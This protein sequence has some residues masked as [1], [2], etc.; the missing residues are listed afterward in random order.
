MIFFLLLFYVH[1]S[2]GFLCVLHSRFHL[3]TS[4]P[5]KVFTA[6]CVESN[7]VKLLVQRVVCIAYYYD[8]L[9]CKQQKYNF[10]PSEVQLSQRRQMGCCSGNVCTF[11][12]IRPCKAA[13]KHLCV[14]V[15]AM[16][17]FIAHDFNFCVIP[18]F[19]S[20]IISL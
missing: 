2:G 12:Y 14:L 20:Y 13:A 4:R 19:K 5:T 17:H 15:W 9:T 8:A 7:K 11:L 16:M 3:W 6:K 18:S 1:T 10:F